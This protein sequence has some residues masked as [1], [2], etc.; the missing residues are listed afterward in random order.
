ML[1]IIGKITAKYIKVLESY[2]GK[3]I[4]Q[5]HKNLEDMKHAIWATFFH[6]ISTD[7]HPQHDLCPKNSW[8]QYNRSNKLSNFKHRH[9]VDPKI[10]KHLW[11]LYT[12][13]TFDEDL[14]KLRHGLTSNCNESFNHK[15]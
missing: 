9:K 7:E 6:H 8:W 10:F 11:S 2:Y 13:L 5:N 12:D 15:I 1:L 14:E 4:R 3:A